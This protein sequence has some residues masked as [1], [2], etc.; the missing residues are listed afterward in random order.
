MQ[1]TTVNATYTR[2]RT[3]AW[4]LR[5]VGVIA[6]G[7]QVRVTTRDGRSK[8]ETVGQIVFAGDGI[9]VATTARD[10]EMRPVQPVEMPAPMPVGQAP[11]AVPVQ[12][13]LE[14]IIHDLEVSLAGLKALRR[15]A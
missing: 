13:D 10:G 8:F 11:V 5:A 2:L 14:Q 12:P 3:G 6:P 7:Q 15:A 1:T 9:T 4:G